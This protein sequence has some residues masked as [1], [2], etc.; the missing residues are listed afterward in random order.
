MPGITRAI[1]AAHRLLPLTWHPIVE[2]ATASAPVNIALAKYWGKRDEQLHLPMT[3]SLSVAL[4]LFTTTTVKKALSPSDEVILNGMCMPPQSA[5]YTRCARFLDLF[6]P[7][8]QFSFSITT[9]N[10][11]PTAAGLA[12]SASG[13]AALTMALNS[14]FGW[15]LS[16]QQVSALSRLGSGSACRSVYKG[17]VRWQKGECP[18]G[19]DSYAIPCKGW[20][21]ELRLAVL[22]LS[23]KEKPISSR[24]AMRLSVETSPYY[25]LWPQIVEKDIHAILTTI[26]ERNFPAFGRLVERNALMMHSTML[27][28]T[29]PVC[30]WIEETITAMKTIW[31]ARHHGIPV[32][33]TIDAGPNIKLLFLS[34]DSQAVM[35][36]FPQAFAVSLCPPSPQSFSL[37]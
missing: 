8:P 35:E 21:P 14:F 31:D 17:F 33:F 37:E 25:D 7:S 32:Y 24:E 4:D 2:E 29:P 22:M 3:D 36:K 27:T 11:V 6:R 30:Y 1:Q 5:F 9:T 10:T 15:K 34:K 26:D 28:S 13:F 20:W 16:S 19:T 23:T 18:E 12:S